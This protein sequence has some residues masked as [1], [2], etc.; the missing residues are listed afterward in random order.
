MALEK[1][2]LPEEFWND[3][4]RGSFVDEEEEERTVEVR[5]D[6]QCPPLPLALANREQPNQIVGGITISASIVFKNILHRGH[7]GATCVTPAPKRKL[8]FS[9]PACVI[10]DDPDEDDQ[11]LLSLAT[12]FCNENVAPPVPKVKEPKKAKTEKPAKKAMKA[13]KA[14][15]AMK[16]IKAMKATKAIKAK[17]GQT[18]DEKKEEASPKPEAMKAIKV[19][20]GTTEDQQKEKIS[21]KPAKKAQLMH[22]R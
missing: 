2:A 3:L 21:P 16:A 14:T 8:S 13:T 9:S 12:S 10:I 6:M 22:C 17:K 18:K 19:K 15:K 1:V 5:V 11:Q 4:K 7:D 20:K